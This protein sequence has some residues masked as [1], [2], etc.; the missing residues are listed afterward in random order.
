MVTHSHPPF[1]AGCAARLRQRLAAAQAERVP[2]VAAAVVADGTLIWQDAIG[3]ADGARPAAVEDQYRI[4]SITKTF[5]AVAALQLRDAGRLALEDPLE[6]HLDAGAAGRATVRQLLTHTSGLQRE[7]PGAIWETMQPPT[8]EQLRTQLPQVERVLEPGAEWHYSNLAF[9]LLGLLVTEVSGVDFQR[10]AVERILAPLGMTRTSWSAQSPSATG[11]FVDPYEDRLHLEADVDCAGTASMGGLWSTVGD[12]ARWIAFLADPDPAVLAPETV[13]E[14]RRAHVLADLDRWSV[15]WGL[16]LKLSRVGE[17][18]YVGH[19]GAMPGFL[20]GIALRPQERVGAAVL[21]N[22][23]SRFDAEALARTLLDEAIA[24]HGAPVAPWRPA[25]EPAPAALT[26]LLGRWWSEGEEFLFC[27]RDGALQA[28]RVDRDGEPPST[29]AADGEDRFR[30]V[31][32][33]ERGELLTVTRAADG[34][35]VQLNWATYPFTREPELFGVE[36]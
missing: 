4:G 25:A 20:A 32:G 21:A 27:F 8:L 11:F 1:D 19:A 12:L 30:T 2:S 28:E 15:G 26:G 24:A 5:A 22:T 13:A 18:V 17:R 35:P 7:P 31:A 36:P 6:R 33:R 23:S 34:A 10:H 9:A 29:F 14:M 16:G 3:T